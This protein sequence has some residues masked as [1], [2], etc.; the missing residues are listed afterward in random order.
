MTGVLS[1]VFY[2]PI[3]LTVVSN[4]TSSPL[5]RAAFSAHRSPYTA[6]SDRSWHRIRFSFFFKHGNP[7][8]GNIN[9]SQI[10]LM[11]FVCI[12]RSF[13]YCRT[14]APARKAR[15]LQT[16]ARN[17]TILSGAYD[18]YYLRPDNHN[19]V[20]ARNLE[21]SMRYACASYCTRNVTRPNPTVCRIFRNKKGFCGTGKRV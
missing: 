15:R 12:R 19:R 17:Y 3:R 4:G 2:G 8:F 11:R 21:S 5:P 7:H 18:K 9:V 13:C 16:N 6:F 1:R 20:D 14:C 10:L